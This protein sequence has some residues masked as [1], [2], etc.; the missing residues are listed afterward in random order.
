MEE[1]EEKVGDMEDLIDNDEVS[2]EEEG[3]LK[4]YEAE[5]EPEDSEDEEEKPEEE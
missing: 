3:F 4:G 1:Y 5:E 2:P